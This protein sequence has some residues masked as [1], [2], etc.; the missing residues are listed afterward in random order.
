VQI[1]LHEVPV[2]CLR[3][4]CIRLSL[5]LSLSDRPHARTCVGVPRSMREDHLPRRLPEGRR[6]GHAEE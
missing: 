6:R 3:H 1:T 2:R 5:S 4:T